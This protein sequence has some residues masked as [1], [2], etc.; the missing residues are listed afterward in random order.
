MARARQ[1]KNLQNRR[2]GALER[3]E[4]SSFTPKKMRDGKDRSEETWTKKK[5]AIIETLKKRLKL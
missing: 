5:E 3:L 4:A 2:K 1:N